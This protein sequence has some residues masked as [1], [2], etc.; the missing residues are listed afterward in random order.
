M[1][2][3][4]PSAPRWFSIYELK[5]VLL[6]A[7]VA[8]TSTG[9]PGLVA[10]V[11]TFKEKMKCFCVV[12]SGVMVASKKSDR[13]ARSTTGVP[14]MPRGTILLPGDADGTGVPTLRCQIMLPLTALSAYTLF[15]SVTAMTIAPF[16]PP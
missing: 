1:P 2:L 14:V 15:D 16:G 5:T 4:T 7:A 10:P 6:Y 3:T 11:S 13:D 9:Q 12:P 8:P